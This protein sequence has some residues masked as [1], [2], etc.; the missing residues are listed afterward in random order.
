M[1]RLLIALLF[2]TAIVFYSTPAIAQQVNPS[3]TVPTPNS[4][5]T[6]GAKDLQVIPKSTGE[7]AQISINI[8]AK[9]SLPK[10]SLLDTSLTIFLPR[11]QQT[12]GM[13]EDNSRVGATGDREVV[14]GC[15]EF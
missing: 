13:L 5:S 7:P 12:C 9:N 3:Q 15:N 2:L 1:N 4:I 10:L 8:D 11:K 14:L 6:S